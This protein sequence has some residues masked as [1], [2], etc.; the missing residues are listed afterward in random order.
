[1]SLS[2]KDRV[3]LEIDHV[4]AIVLLVLLVALL[5]VHE[6]RSRDRFDDL[7]RAHYPECIVETK[8]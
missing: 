4:P 3:S 5:T 6:I 8:P 1:M 7:C 2:A